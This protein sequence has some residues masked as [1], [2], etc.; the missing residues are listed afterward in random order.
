[1]MPFR[2]DDDF[3]VREEVI[4]DIDECFSRNTSSHRVALVGLGGIG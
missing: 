1:M 2:K 3:V 4:N